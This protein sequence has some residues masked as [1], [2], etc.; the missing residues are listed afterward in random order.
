MNINKT[1]YQ[2][3]TYRNAV[4]KSGAVQ[5]MLFEDISKGINVNLAKTLNGEESEETPMDLIMRS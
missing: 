4:Q 5:A 3:L 2:K 1:G